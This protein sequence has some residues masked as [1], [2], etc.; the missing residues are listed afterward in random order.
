[1]NDQNLPTTSSSALVPH[2]SAAV[3]AQN[4]SVSAMNPDEMARSQHALVAW[5]YAK[6]AEL[7]AEL[8][9]V[10][11]ARDTAVRRKWAA[12]A[13]NRQ[14]TKAQKRLDFYSKLLTALE[15]GYTIVPN[16]PVTAFAIRTNR[17]RPARLWTTSYREKHTQKCTGLPEGEG[18]Y[19][20]PFPLVVQETLTPATTTANE[21]AAYWADAWKELEFPLT[22]AKAQLI[23]ATSEAMKLKVFDEIGILPGYAPS[24]GTRPP[25]G[26]PII[27]G[28]LFDPT[29][30][31]P[32]DRHYVSF[33]ICWHLHTKDL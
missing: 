11:D 19:Q 16:F 14:I 5:A 21:K 22:M 23:E 2:S 13:L 24:E 1:M 12:G 9:D 32:Y 20:N 3:P 25:K 8:K 30:S 4:V 10:T 17:E 28:R 31:S 29:R 7:K 6:V 33:I 26:D 15:H 27:I 18:A